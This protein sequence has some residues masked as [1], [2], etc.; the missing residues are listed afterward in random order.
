MSQHKS[1]RKRE[2]AN[3]DVLTG[4]SAG[5]L[6]WIFSCSVQKMKINITFMKEKKKIK[7]G[8]SCLV[9]ILN[10]IQNQLSSMTHLRSSRLKYMY[11]LYTESS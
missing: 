9:N 6:L 1:V 8:C 7:A 11:A 2:K 10:L 4:N 3:S 5:K